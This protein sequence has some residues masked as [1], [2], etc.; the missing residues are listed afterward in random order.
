VDPGAKVFGI[1]LSRTGTTSLADALEGLGVS[2]IH[3]PSDPETRRELISFLDGET[4]A[5]RLSVLEL[6][7]ALT[8]TPVCAAYRALDQAYPGSKFIL[9]TRDE[10]E[11][12]RSC[13]AYWTMARTSKLRRQLRRV[14]LGRRQLA[15]RLRGEDRLIEFPL[16]VATINRAVYGHPRPGREHFRAAARTYERDAAAYFADRPEDLL[17]MDICGGDGWDVLCPFLGLPVPTTPFPFSNQ[18]VNRDRAESALAR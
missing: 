15:A 9:T 17:I 3:F 6:V 10:D 8:D 5:L 7:D 14:K 16:Y 12:L 1:G 4:A 11:W 13:E 18:L 2:T